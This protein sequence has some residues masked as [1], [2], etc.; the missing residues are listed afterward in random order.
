MDI[1]ILETNIKKTLKELKQKHERTFQTHKCTDV[2]IFF[3]INIQHI[4]IHQI[5]TKLYTEMPTV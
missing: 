4:T 5:Y 2:Q 3:Y 1:D